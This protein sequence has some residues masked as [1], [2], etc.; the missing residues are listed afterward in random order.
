MDV[1]DVKMEDSADAEGSKLVLN[2][3]GVRYKAIF[4]VYA[5][6]LYLG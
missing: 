5:A 6:S 4:K 3:A 1:G 2:G